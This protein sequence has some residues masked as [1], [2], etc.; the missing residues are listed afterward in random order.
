MTT[1][2]FRKLATLTVVL[3][4]VIALSSGCGSDSMGPDLTGPSDLSS[5]LSA[6]SDGAQGPVDSGKKKKGQETQKAPQSSTVTK[7]IDGATGG[8]VVNGAYKVWFAPGAFAG[9]Q[10][11]T[12]TDTKSGDGSC[13]LGPEGLHFL[14][15]VILT[16][17]VEGTLYDSPFVT[18]EWY[19]PSAAAWVD[20]Y[21]VY[22]D[23]THTVY[24]YL[25]HFS[26]YRP[27]AG[28]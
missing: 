15:P 26:Q 14:R 8:E 18:I 16:I 11:I 2:R 6:R 17:N 1:V 27:R 12:L 20:I 24:A 4:S 22:S 25:A 19:D 28:W 10:T 3:T 9:S 7:V 21:G 5:P 23:Y 13:I